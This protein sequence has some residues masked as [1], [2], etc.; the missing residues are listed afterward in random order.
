MYIPSLS[1]Q[2]VSIVF[3]SSSSLSFCPAAG[4]VYRY[5]IVPATSNLIGRTTPHAGMQPGI[6]VQSVPSYNLLSNKL[7][8]R[9]PPRVLCSAGFS[10]SFINN[11][12][13][14]MEIKD[15]H[16]PGPRAGRPLIFMVLNETD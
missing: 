7:F 3:L 2:T 14:R 1:R 16:R 6:S 15:Q 13:R 9:F 11:V 8:A 10:G 5:T 4:A 12:R